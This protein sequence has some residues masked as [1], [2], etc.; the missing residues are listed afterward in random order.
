MH[1]LMAIDGSTTSQAA[2]EFVRQFPFPE[3]TEVT[4]LTVLPSIDPASAKRES[5]ERE[6]AEQAA[7]LLA[8]A[9]DRLKGTGWTTHTQKREGHAA[10][11]I[12]QA[13]SKLGADLAVV[14]SH[15]YGPIHRFLLGSVSQKV[16]K[17]APCS[18]LVV[19][20]ATEGNPAEPAPVPPLRI[21]AAYD[22]SE[23][24]DRAIHFLASLP[25]KDRAQVQVV[26]VLVLITFYRMDILQTQ[27]PEWHSE[28]LRARE[29]LE[30]AEEILRQATS[31]VT[32]Q[33]R[34]ERDEG[35]GIL[36]AAGEFDADLVVVGAT[37]RSGI[38]RF[39]LGSVSNRVVLHS[40][41]SVLVIR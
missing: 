15:G 5:L 34:G 40:H 17:Y 14:G 37:G 9:T 35:E 13:C 16:M 6:M 39:L 22:A 24:A 2:V 38:E 30:R 18:V 25:L 33:L 12:V 27:S 28:Q 20:A 41:R 32:S 29:A 10:D 11:Q 36:T 7:R 4:L 3:A 26:T 8:E 21:L 19:R 23:S 31:D 1:I